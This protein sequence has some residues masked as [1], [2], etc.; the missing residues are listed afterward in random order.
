MTY[1]KQTWVNG[2]V[3]GTP[4]NDTRL[5]ILE[6]GLAFADIVVNVKAF[7]ALG[8]GTTN[9][10]TA[11]QAAIDASTI[12]ST[13]FFP[14]GTYLTTSTIK[15]RE[16]RTYRGSHLRLSIIKQ[17]PATTALTAVV[18]SFGFMQNETIPGEPIVIEDLT[19][20]GNKAN[21]SGGNTNGIQLMNR[22]STIQRVHIINMTG[23]CIKIVDRNLAGTAA[24]TSGLIEYNNILQCRM[25]SPNG[26]G[27]WGLDTDGKI[28]NTK[29][30]HNEILSTGS[31]GVEL[32]NGG[33]SSVE[34]NRLFN[35]ARSGI[36]VG[37]STGSRIH[38]NYIEGF[39]TTATVGVYLG[40]GIEPLT[41]RGTIVTDNV[42]QS[43]EP[44]AGSTYR[45]LSAKQTE[46]G[47]TTNSIIKGNMVHGNNTALG[48]GV[49]LESAVDGVL[50]GVLGINQIINVTTPLSQVD[51]LGGAA[52]AINTATTD[53]LANQTSEVNDAIATHDTDPGAHEAADFAKMISDGGGRTIYVSNTTPPSSSVDG[54][55]W[56]DTSVT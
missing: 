21:N 44:T 22:L 51:A 26:R 53:D 14:P 56:V 39:G 40:I 15:F 7:G 50:N 30:A 49:Y 2:A 13:I 54:D 37:K 52:T 3:G 8:D 45:Y 29:I 24:L 20:D 48:V 16:G 17:S 28:V 38:G 23:A 32:S 27:I 25:E 12:G 11:I 5:N 18:A 6:N 55:L 41:N 35:I 4:L 33:G 36:F 42:V 10:A 43:A 47:V 31:L 9:D 1:T 46:S 34:S 19:I